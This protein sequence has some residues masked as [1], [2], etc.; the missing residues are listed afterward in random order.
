MKLFKWLRGLFGSSK[1]PE[2]PAPF[3]F[4]TPG[5]YRPEDVD[6][7]CRATR[8]IVAEAMN[9]GDMLVGHVDE[10]GNLVI[11]RRSKPT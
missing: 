6:S 3:Q 8:E 9:S 4:G 11:D 1:V 7:P 2:K 10:N 5:K